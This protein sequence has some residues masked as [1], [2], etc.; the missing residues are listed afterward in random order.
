MPKFILEQIAI[1]P[2][3]REAAIELLKAIGLTQ[4]ADDLVVAHGEVFGIMDC[5]NVADLAFNYQTAH[6]VAG[7]VADPKPLE[8]EVLNYRTGENWM[9]GREGSASHL[10]M[11][12]TEVE[13]ADWRRFFERRNIRVAQ[14]VNTLSHTN[15]VI[16]GKRKYKYVI[17][18]TRR[19]LGID[20]KF[21]VR[22]DVA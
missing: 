19:I 17:F 8:F 11:H 5:T 10:G 7:S 21:I 1:V 6:G 20:L 4:W 14:E 16:A 12:C 3:Q 9:Q 18:D 13:L 22:K 15:P 2:P